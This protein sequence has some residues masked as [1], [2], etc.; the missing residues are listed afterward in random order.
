MI[1]GG[2]D[3]YTFRDV[4]IE[5]IL[6][7]SDKQHFLSHTKHGYW[8]LL[9]TLNFYLTFNFL[10][11]NVMSFL[12]LTVTIITQEAAIKKYLWKKCFLCWL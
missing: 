5:K 8:L 6:V 10:D 1:S 4:W 12:F 2:F 9:M 3:V 11:R 7:M